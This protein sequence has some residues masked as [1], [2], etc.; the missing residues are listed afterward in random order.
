MNCAYCGQPAIHMDHVVPKSLQRKWHVPKE[1]KGTVP[2]CGPCNWRKG[3]R[4][5][6]PPSW[7]KHV[8][9]LNEFFGGSPFRVWHGDVSEPA[10]A[11]VHR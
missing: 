4:R 2:C 10:F 5:L 8:E 11:Q 6:V 9:A 3:T 1:W 7:E